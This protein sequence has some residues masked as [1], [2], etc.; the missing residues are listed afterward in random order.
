MKRHY[1][2]RVTLPETGEFYWGVRSCNCEPKDDTYKG[3][4]KGWKVDKTKLVK[5]DIIEYATRE[6]ANVAEEV[7]I[8]YFIDKNKFP[9]NRNYKIGNQ[10]FC[11]FGYKFSEESKLKMSK[12]RIGKKLSDETKQKMTESNKG[13]NVGRTHSLEQNENHSEI[14]R[15]RKLCEEHKQKISESSKGKNKGKI[16]WNAGKSYSRKIK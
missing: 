12:S 13:K 8:S 7:V 4:M 2:Y 5:T 1:I 14:M 6:E 3:S 11:M 16:P 15:G 10:A 9:L